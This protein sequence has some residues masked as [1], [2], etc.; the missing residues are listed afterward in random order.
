MC[1][2][3]RLIY[4]WYLGEGGG[5]KGEGRGRGGRE[6]VSRFAR[7]WGQILNAYNSETVRAR[8]LNVTRFRGIFP[9]ES[10]GMGLETIG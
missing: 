8:P 3:R 2:A 7:F 10:N 6:G 5:E 9:G 4:A 1:F